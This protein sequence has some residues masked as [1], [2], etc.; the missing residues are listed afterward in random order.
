MIT[1]YDGFCVETLNIINMI[2]KA[3]KENKLNFVR[4]LY[5]VSWFEFM[6]FLEYKS[7]WYS[8]YFVKIDKFFPSTRM[9]PFC[10]HIQKEITLDDRVLTCP[11]CGR[12]MDRDPRAALTILQEGI[13]LL[14]EFYKIPQE[15][16]ELKTVGES[17]LAGAFDE[18]V[19][20]SVS[21]QAAKKAK[22]FKA[23]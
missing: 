17:S 8:K 11:H 16:W 5:D 7:F 12:V 22:A 4:S 14:K 15:P 20:S 1:K 23:A 18:A 3:K 21:P 19:T 13:R 9:C 10:G 2:K 6:K